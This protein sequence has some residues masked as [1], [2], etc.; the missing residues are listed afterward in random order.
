MNNLEALRERLI[1]ASS[2]AEK[3]ADFTHTD[4]IPAFCEGRACHKRNCRDCFRD[5]LLEEADER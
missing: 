1:E 4:P 5:W 2:D 3:L